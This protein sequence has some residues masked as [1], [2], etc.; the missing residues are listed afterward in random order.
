LQVRV[1]VSGAGTTT[2][3]GKAW[4]EGSAEPA[5]WQVSATDDTAELQATGAVGLATYLSGSA[6]AVPTTVSVTDYWAGAAGTQP[7]V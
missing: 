5:D 6:T 4:L 7:A 1:D 3:Q 2:L